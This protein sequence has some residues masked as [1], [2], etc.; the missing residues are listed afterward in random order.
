M[1]YNWQERFL[2][3]YAYE[4]RLKNNVTRTSALDLF[5]T[6]LNCSGN[7]EMVRNKLYGLGKTACV[8][9]CRY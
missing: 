3:G 9:L 7:T 5:R 6:P 4:L 1:P 8:D 2:V